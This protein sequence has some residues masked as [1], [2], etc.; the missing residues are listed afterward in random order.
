MLP[1]S[2]EPIE[3]DLY[4]LQGE[5]PSSVSC[6]DPPLPALQLRFLHPV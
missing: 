2:R 1:H 3:S 6:F 4:Q 5:V